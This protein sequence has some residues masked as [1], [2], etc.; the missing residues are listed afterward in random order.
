MTKQKIFQE[1]NIA[2]PY[3][4]FY[5]AI[6][7]FYLT[8]SSIVSHFLESALMVYIFSFVG[9]FVL[10]ITGLSL[11]NKKKLGIVLL[12]I[13][14]LFF[15]ILIPTI[16]PIYVDSFKYSADIIFVLFAIFL[17]VVNW[18]KWRDK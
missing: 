17:T 3:F 7:V 12:W 1:I 14:L 11:L 15:I 4:L 6:A 18:K 8:V 5:Q 9:V 10:I 2:I 16:R 13:Y